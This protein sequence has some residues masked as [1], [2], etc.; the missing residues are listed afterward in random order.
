MKNTLDRPMIKIQYSTV[1]VRIEEQMSGVGKVTE[2][3]HFKDILMTLKL[4]G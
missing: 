2:K 4:I 1:K 3:K